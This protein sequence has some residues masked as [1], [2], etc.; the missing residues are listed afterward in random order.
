MA[1]IF[2]RK[3]KTGKGYTWRV[4]IRR[5]GYPTICKTF[6]RQQQA[7]DCGYEIENK[8]TTG[9]YKFGQQGTKQTFD[10]LVDRYIPDDNRKTDHLKS[11]QCSKIK[12]TEEF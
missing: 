10:H 3:S 9:Q 6:S 1:S 2:K 4:V 11:L 7:E 8:I 12:R 5:K